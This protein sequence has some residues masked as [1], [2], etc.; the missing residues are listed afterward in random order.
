MK[1]SAVAISGR[2]EHRCPAVD[3]RLIGEGLALQPLFNKLSRLLGQMAGMA[4]LASAGTEPDRQ[5]CH[6]AS[7]KAQLQAAHEA[8]ARLARP[9]HLAGTFHAMGET[10]ALMDETMARLDRRPAIALLDDDSFFALTQGLSAA[11]RLLVT[12]SAPGLGIV[13]FA[14]ACCALGH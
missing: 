13:D 1:P 5:V 11:R 14:G 6:L 3:E 12:A 8:Y 4:L 2:Q 10:L 9:R 7:V